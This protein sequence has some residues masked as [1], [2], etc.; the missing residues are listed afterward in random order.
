MFFKNTTH[1]NKRDGRTRVIISTCNG[2]VCLVCLLTHFLG[3]CKS[4]LFFNPRHFGLL[5][6]ASILQ[7]TKSV[8]RFWET[9]EPDKHAASGL[10]RAG[11]A[12]LPSYYQWSISI[13]ADTSTDAVEKT[14]CSSSSSNNTKAPTW[15]VLAI[16][17]PLAL[18][19]RCRS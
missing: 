16:T 12:V 18:A 4:R 5:Q 17:I 19:R 13:N 3:C 15:R 7:T 14:Y 6:I 1:G 10:I 2:H 11:R 8:S 9:S